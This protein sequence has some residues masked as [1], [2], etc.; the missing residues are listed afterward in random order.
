MSKSSLSN[1]NVPYAK[2]DELRDPVVAGPVKS[3]FVQPPIGLSSGQ[4]APHGLRRAP[5]GH[6]RGLGNDRNAQC[7]IPSVAATSIYGI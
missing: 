3:R 5:N 2:P 7:G 1:G 6:V 4:H